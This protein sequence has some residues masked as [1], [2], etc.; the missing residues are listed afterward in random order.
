M[1]LLLEFS[2][3]DKFAENRYERR[4]WW[5]APSTFHGMTDGP[6]F[7]LQMPCADG[8]LCEP[9]IEIQFR[10]K[11]HWARAD[12]D[13]E[14]VLK[15]DD[16]NSI[17]KVIPGKKDERKLVEDQDFFVINHEDELKPNLE[18]S[19]APSF[20]VLLKVVLNHEN[21]GYSLNI[22]AKHIWNE[23]WMPVCYHLLQWL[24]YLHSIWNEVVDFLHASDSQNRS[25]L[26]SRII[27][28]L[29]IR[30]VV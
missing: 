25:R 14:I 5:H 3:R 16:V 12:H 6:L 1:M 22:N 10:R 21:W 28:F 27:P 9:N 19:S 7:L 17:E 13:S 26:V 15:K 29:C 2:L 30:T 11:N 23:A 20:L 24:E 4:I 8:Y 18:V